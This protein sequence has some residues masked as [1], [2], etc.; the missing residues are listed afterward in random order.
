MVEV[1]FFNLILLLS[2]K[3]LS[4]PRGS[5]S[6]KLGKCMHEVVS[7][8]KLQASLLSFLQNFP[9]G[10]Q[11]YW[12]VNICSF[13]YST[14]ETFSPFSH[15]LSQKRPT[16]YYCMWWVL[17]KGGG[18]TYLW[19]MPC[20]H[21]FTMY[22]WWT[23]TPRVSLCPL[24]LSSHGAWSRASALQVEFGELVYDMYT[25]GEHTRVP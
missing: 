15:P 6:L 2:V 7:V 22:S 20:Y 23:V 25:R 13:K 11:I 9:L 5:Q 21:T 10:Q 19:M 16:T 18:R 3:R 24:L 4:R 12:L 8:K 14:C 1:S 17:Y